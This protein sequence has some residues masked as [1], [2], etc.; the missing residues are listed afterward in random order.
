M[1]TLQ[2]THQNSLPLQVGLC[3]CYCQSPISLRSLRTNLQFDKVRFIVSLQGGEPRSRVIM[4]L[5][6]KGKSRVIEFGG[7]IE[8][9]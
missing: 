5:L 1:L 2:Q 6:N 3:A 4:E 7:R 9:G 8:S